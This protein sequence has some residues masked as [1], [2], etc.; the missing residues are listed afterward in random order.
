MVGRP[1]KKIVRHWHPKKLKKCINKKER[2]VEV[3]R[4]LYVV[5]DL[6]DG[7]KP[8]NIC[9]KRDIS[10]PTLHSWWD[11]WNEEGYDGLYSKYCN[12]GRPPKL[13]P[14][15]KVKLNDIL[16]KEDYLN[17]KKVAKIIKDN[18][19]V[20][21]S[22]SHQ[23]VVLK[24]LGFLYNKPYQFYSKRPDDAEEILKKAY[25]KSD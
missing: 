4:R 14:E 18:F 5:L 21:Y 16:E 3:L 2:N 22:L 15:D 24:E 10:L 25:Q 9:K 20:V 7:K 13:S 17:Q 11:R 19:N 6:Y 12:G 1:Q 8:D 23:S